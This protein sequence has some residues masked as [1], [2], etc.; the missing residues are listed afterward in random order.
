LSVC[1]ILISNKPN[2]GLPANVFAFVETLTWLS[3]SVRSGARTYFESTPDARIK[4]LQ[5]IL[6]TIAPKELIKHYR[7]GATYLKEPDQDRPVDKW[8]VEKERD[9][10]A[11]LC[12]FVRSHREEFQALIG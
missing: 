11:W 10:D 1:S 7:L 6:E 5:Q 4:A 2:Y 3:Q 8:I 9:L 12:E